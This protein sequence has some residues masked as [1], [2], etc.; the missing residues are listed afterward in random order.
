MTGARSPAG[1]ARVA[2]L[3]LGAE[4]GEATP[5]ASSGATTGATAGPTSEVTFGARGRLGE[6]FRGL[7]EEDAPPW[8]WLAAARGLVPWLATPAAAEAARLRGLPL[9]GPSPAVVS[10]VHDKSFAAGLAR[11]ID[12]VG[13]LLVVLEPAEATPARIE[14]EVARWPAWARAR[15]TVKP[16]WGTS[17]RGRIAGVDGRLAV[18]HGALLPLESLARRGGEVLEPWLERT[19]DL[20][21]L[22]FVD[23]RGAPLLLGVTRPRTRGAGVYLGCDIAVG[24]SGAAIALGSGTPHDEPAVAR[25]RP[26]VAAAARAGFRGPCGVDA[27]LYRDPTAAAASAEVAL[28]GVVELNARFTAGHV[29]LG[30]VLQRGP[31]PGARARFSLDHDE[32]LT[33]VTEGG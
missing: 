12:E 8:P 27:F 21:S 26:V 1:P 18:R 3:N 22:W 30:L 23:E 10:R 15:F 20:S 5:S 25:A 24:A 2:W 29:A 16:R 33:V 7:V 17:G 9:W 4:E 14:Q 32:L 19:T 28:R 11:D 6:A 31:P 13:P